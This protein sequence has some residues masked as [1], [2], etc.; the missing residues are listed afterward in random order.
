MIEIRGLAKAYG[1]RPVLRDVSFGVEA[2]ERVALLGVNGAGKT[3][4][5]RCLLGLVSYDGTIRVEGVDARR[6]GVQA[7]SRLGYVPQ[8]A[9]VSDLPAGEFV[10]MIAGLRGVEPE[11]VAR[12]LDALGLDLEAEA[13]KPLRALSGGMLQ[14]TLL[15]L[16][17][18]DG[19]STLL[20][21]EPTGNL[22]AAARREFLAALREVD[23][24]T[25]VLLASHQI[26]DVQAIADRILVLHDGGVAFDG[27]VDELRSHAEAPGTLWV[28]ISGKGKTEARRLLDTMPEA[29]AVHQ[30]GGDLIRVRSLPRNRAPLVHA[31]E[32]EGFEVTDVRT[33]E[34]PL[35]EVLARLARGGGVRAGRSGAGHRNGGAGGSARERSSEGRPPAGGRKP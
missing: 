32:R 26:S 34:E 14:K 2:G 15:A 6:H 22:D 25:T 30:N 16:V 17:L 7:R 10:E 8:R 28:R 19:V 35:E 13:D 4:L 9:P 27:G 33:E 24:A 31:L 3:T 1:D 29:L 11:A 23:P 20:L 21:D 5:L 12:V 18:A